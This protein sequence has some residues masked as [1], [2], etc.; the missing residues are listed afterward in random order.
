MTPFEIAFTAVGLPFVGYLLKTRG[1]YRID[2]PEMVVR[3]RE[4]AAYSL[5]IHPAAKK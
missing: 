2:D 3:F 4:T 1:A 5:T